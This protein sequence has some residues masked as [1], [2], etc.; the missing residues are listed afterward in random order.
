MKSH[1]GSNVCPTCGKTISLN[2]S[3]CAAC[4][5]APQPPRWDA[6]TSPLKISFWAGSPAAPAFIKEQV[7]LEPKNGKHEECILLPWRDAFAVLLRANRTWFHFHPEDSD[8]QV[9]GWLMEQSGL[10]PLSP[11]TDAEIAKQGTYWPHLPPNPTPADFAAEVLMQ[12]YGD[13]QQMSYDRC[14][15]RLVGDDMLLNGEIEAAAQ[16]AHQTVY[17]PLAAGLDAWTDPA[18]ASLPLDA[19]KDPATASLSNSRKTKM[20]RPDHRLLLKRSY[21]VA[22]TGQSDI[23]PLT[24]A[25]DLG[26]TTLFDSAL[27]KGLIPGTRK[28]TLETGHPL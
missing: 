3:A 11:L 16:D 15:S 23:N 12:Y 1:N 17:L 2:K 26:D 24:E 25:I 9:N 18:V 22:Y 6:E 28:I 21:E 14:L 13:I 10:F 19:W 27:Q 8:W 20:M 4:L 7:A 5:A